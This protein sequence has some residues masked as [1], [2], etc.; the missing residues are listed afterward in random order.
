[1]LTGPRRRSLSSLLIGAALGSLALWLAARGLDPA[2]LAAALRR[3]SLPLTL[4]A[5]A[6]T[7][8]ALAAVA[9]RWQLL[10][11]PRHRDRQF[12]T[13]LRATIVGQM[14]N[15]VVPLRLGELARMY[16]VAQREGLSQATVLTTLAIEKALDLSAFAIAS[17]ATLA[18]VAAP[19][20]VTVR[21]GTL[22]AAGAGGLL[23]L[24]LIGR[25][26]G[27]LTRV[28]VRIAERLPPVAARPIARATRHILDG[29]SALQHTRAGLASIVMTALIVWLS[30]FAN[31]LLLEAFGL[32]LPATA[33]LLVLV[34]IQA[35]SVPPSLP[36]KIGI[37]NY[38]T[39]VA[40][41]VFGV[42]RETGLA[43]SIALYGVALLPKVLAGA[44]LLAIAPVP[45][46]RQRIDETP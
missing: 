32:H 27:R 28:V 38:L 23:I 31:Y 9:L 10:F 45:F 22:W 29:L 35:G 18:Y 44:V 24:W 46:S 26:S 7:L 5:L 42:D 21:S 15:I 16:L 4:A 33:A 17:A 36:G 19:S 8:A 11:Y 3:P 41:A 34:L 30:A 37:F 20:E 14:L 43:Y 40:L 6:T 13:L 39:V 2:A 1:M 25:A 12:S